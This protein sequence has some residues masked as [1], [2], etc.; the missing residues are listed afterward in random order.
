MGGRR[1]HGEVTDKS[2]R[3]LPFDPEKFM[4]DLRQRTLE[5]RQVVHLRPNAS[6]MASALRDFTDLLYR[7]LEASRE[8]AAAEAQSS[9][10]WW[11]PP[12][13]SIAEAD[14]AL[15]D[16]LVDDFCSSQAPT[17]TQWLATNPTRNPTS[18]AIAFLKRCTQTMTD[19]L[20]AMAQLMESQAHIRAP[21]T[22]ARTVL[23]AG[24]VG[25][26]VADP[27]ASS[28]ERLRRVLN[29]H[30]AQLK[31]AANEAGVTELRGDYDAQIDELRAFARLAGFDVKYKTSGHLPP[32]ILGEGSTRADSA[33]AMVKRILPGVGVSMWRSLSAVA[34]S[35]NSLMVLPDDYAPP[36]TVQAWQRAETIAWH[37]LPALGVTHELSSTSTTGSWSG[38]TP[39]LRPVSSHGNRSSSSPSSAYLHSRRAIQSSAGRVHYGS[40]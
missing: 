40:G 9:S 20:S 39:T 23:E 22:L 2:D 18:W 11:L 29:L 26:F 24:A 6:Q 31:E 25:C 3:K 36:H 10:G 19:H 21:I 33:R 12:A 27:E 5:H 28:D 15:H 13:G 37:A 34:H 32:V 38:P 8:L 30:F 7:R 4:E 14:V 35:R 1:D 17:Q 16:Q